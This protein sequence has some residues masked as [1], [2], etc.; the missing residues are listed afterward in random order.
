MI[1]YLIIVDYKSI[2]INSTKQEK[3]VIKYRYIA[4]IY[5]SIVFICRLMVSKQFTIYK[6]Q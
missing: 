5:S 6:N 4:Y 3:K 2:T 1:Y